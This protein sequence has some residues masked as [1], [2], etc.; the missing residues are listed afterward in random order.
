MTM[1]G[2]KT[3]LRRS[4][5]RSRFRAAALRN[6]I[7]VKDSVGGVGQGG[8]ASRGPETAFSQ[9]LVSLAVLDFIPYIRIYYP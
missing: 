5:V 4:H 1:S 7:V 9:R 2:M 3:A 8:D 6:L